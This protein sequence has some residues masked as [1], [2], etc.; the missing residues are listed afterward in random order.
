[1]NYYHTELWFDMLPRG[2]EVENEKHK[3]INEMPV[4]KLLNARVL[5]L[6]SLSG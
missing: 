1:M 3:I 2:R 4:N 5:E 6:R